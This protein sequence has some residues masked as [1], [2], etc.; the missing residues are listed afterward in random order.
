M[1]AY[2]RTN[3]TILK[4]SSHILTLIVEKL[5]LVISIIKRRIQRQRLFEEIARGLTQ[6]K[7]E[8]TNIFIDLFM[9]AGYA[10]VSPLI[11]CYACNNEILLVKRPDVEKPDETLTSFK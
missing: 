10:P 2:N 9:P 4:R 8:N 5:L 11:K 3:F 1:W 7:L 6:D